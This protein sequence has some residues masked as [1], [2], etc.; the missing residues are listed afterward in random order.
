M[1]FNQ[2]QGCDCSVGQESA[3]RFNELG[4]KVY[5]TVHSQSGALELKQRAVFPDKMIVL[6]LDVTK[7]DSINQIV[8]YVKKD[9]ATTG[10]LLWAVINGAHLDTFGPLEL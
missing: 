5:A 6:D 1:N 7:D 9:L 4:F 10:C 3:I 2:M 8:D